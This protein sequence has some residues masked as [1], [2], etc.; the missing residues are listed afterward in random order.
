MFKI[1][2]VMHR[3]ASE[4]MITTCS[5][6]CDA[7]ISFRFGVNKQHMASAAVNSIVERNFLHQDHQFE[8]NLSLFTGRLVLQWN[9]RIYLLSSAVTWSIH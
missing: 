1:L 2:V 8:S 3:M 5:I 9:T 7:S 4:R 6:E